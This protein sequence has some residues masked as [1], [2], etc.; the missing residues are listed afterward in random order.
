MELRRHL[1]IGAALAAAAACAG[2]VRRFPL[3]DR[4]SYVVRIGQEVPTTVLF[5][6]RITALDGANL[7]T[8]DTGAP[9]QLAHQPG[10]G[11]F[12]VR[13]LRPEARAAVNVLLRGQVIALEFRTG[14][15]PD[16]TVTFFD[17]AREPAGAAPAR[18]S[19][20]ARC[21]SLLDRAKNH[22]ELAAQHPVVAQQ[23][24]RAVPPAPLG[25]DGPAE[26][27]VEVFR[28]VAE[29]ALVFR[30]RV[31]NRSAAM[32]RYAP[33]RLGIL[34]ANRLYPA[35]ITDARGE[36]PAGAAEELWLAIVGEP[37]GRRAELS[38][39]NTFTPVVPLLP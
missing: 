26:S 8:D 25:A 37:D 33:A 34:V 16:R 4:T 39:E 5:P 32:V 30:L 9:V 11:Y 20:A 10:A 6:D 2:E 27:V 22:A 7:A 38:L 12:S 1:L 15:N 13:A 3:D 29:D 35:A 18:G 31:E 21:L 14:E 28:F 23:I 17:P 24:E 19:R 36:I